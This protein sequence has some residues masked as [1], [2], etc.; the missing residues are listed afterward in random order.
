[1]V[2]DVLDRLD[3]RHI[4]SLRLAGLNAHACLLVEKFDEGIVGHVFTSI[5]KPLSLDFNIVLYLLE[6]LV[7]SL[8][9]H[10]CTHSFWV[11]VVHVGEAHPSEFCIFIVI[12]FVK[13]V[14][15]QLSVSFIF[16]NIALRVHKFADRL[17]FLVKRWSEEFF[18][19]LDSPEF[20]AVFIFGLV[21]F[22]IIFI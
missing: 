17:V 13:W 9:L 20:Y 12:T 22:L 1:M 6:V 10:R 2:L 3:V 11:H 19:S 8:V 5:N 16:F 14:P 18:N 7:Q 15:Q 4:C 21:S